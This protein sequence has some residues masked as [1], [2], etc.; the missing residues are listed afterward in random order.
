[1][2]RPSA[3]RDFARRHAVTRAFSDESSIPPMRALFMSQR[4]VLWDEPTRITMNTAVVVWRLVRI[5][6]LTEGLP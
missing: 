1:M 6:S 5:E 4:A 3:P 2:T